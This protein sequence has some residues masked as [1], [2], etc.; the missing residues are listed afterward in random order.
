[1]HSDPD[2]LSGLESLFLKAST[3]SAPVI[4]AVIASPAAATTSI[5]S[6][7]KLLA[8][9]TIATA[10]FT[11][12]LLAIGLYIRRISK[13]QLPIR[14]PC[15]LALNGIVMHHLLMPVVVSELHVVSDRVGKPQP[16]VGVFFL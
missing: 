11:C 10:A 12:V 4:P 9:F 5:A 2:I 3:A 14:D 15:E 8:L 16:L 7:L 6:V 13:G 1:M